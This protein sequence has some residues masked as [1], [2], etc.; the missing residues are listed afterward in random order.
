MPPGPT[1]T[2]KSQVVAL[3]DGKSFP[4]PF[5]V[6]KVKKK[7]I[8]TGIYMPSLEL[9]GDCRILYYLDPSEPKQRQFK[10]LELIASENFTNQ[11]VIE[12]VGSCLT[13]K[14]SGRFT[15][16]KEKKKKKKRIPWDTDEKRLKEYFRK[17]GEVVEAVIMRNR[18]KAEIRLMYLS[19]LVCH[20]QKRKEEERH[21]RTL[22]KQG[23]NTQPE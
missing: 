5:D 17:Y 3:L 21:M 1:V 6:S 8:F 19:F 23:I 2:Y 7:D 9:I 15:R 18:A 4:L 11:A 14:Y 22:Q 13:N 10:N 16:V 12:A 20:L